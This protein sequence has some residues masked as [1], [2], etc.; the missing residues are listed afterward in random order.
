MEQPELDILIAQVNDELTKLRSSIEESKRINEELTSLKDSTIQNINGYQGEV[1]SLKNSTTGNINGYQ[2]EVESLKN[3]TTGNINGYQGEVESLKNSTIQNINTISD[4]IKATNDAAKI[5][6]G[7]LE[8]KQKSITENEQKISDFL[9]KI[10]SNNTAIETIAK[11]T[12]DW[13]LEITLAKSE[14]ITNAN[15]YSAQNLKSKTLLEQIEETHIRI[16][17]KQDEEGNSI[18]GYLQET[19]DFKNKIAS[20]LVEQQTKFTAQFSEIESLL[21]G[22]TSVGLARAYQIQKESYKKPIELW[23]IIFIIT[24]SLM[25]ALSVILLI[26]QFK[27]NTTQQLTLTEALISLLKDLPF[28]I[29]T[30]WLAGYASKQQS[31]YKRLQQEYAFKEA[32]AKSFHGHKMQIEELMKEGASD[33]DLLLQLVA[34]LVYIT[35]QNPSQTLDNNSHNDSSPFMKLIEGMIPSFKNNKKDEKETVK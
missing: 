18:K 20:F 27:N 16:F 17:G 25:T 26:V 12:Q 15:E 33:K 34:Q 8:L 3:S 7:E 11:N 6:L 9:V 13:Q 21:P 35:S 10:E 23:S 2:G 32:N 1:E 28:F 5:I 22:A 4:E 30:I 31:Q 24:I 14:I 29:P 19:E